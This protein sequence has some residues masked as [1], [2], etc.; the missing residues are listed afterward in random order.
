M[1]KFQLERYDGLID[2]VV[3][4]RF[5]GSAYRSTESL[6]NFPQCITQFVLITVVGAYILYLQRAPGLRGI[7]AKHGSYIP[8][9]PTSSSRSRLFQGSRR[10]R[11]NY[12]DHATELRNFPRSR[13]LCLLATFRSTGKKIDQRVRDRVIFLSEMFSVC[14]KARANR[15]R[16]QATVTAIYTARTLRLT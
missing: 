12:G 10:P 8:T 13:F 7:V 15:S 16:G 5:L 9:R 14:F 11:R 6:R 1:N 3:N 2:P 4:R